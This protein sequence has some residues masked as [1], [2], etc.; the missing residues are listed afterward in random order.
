MQHGT[1]VVPKTTE[2]CYS[3]DLYAPNAHCTKHVDLQQV[4]NCINVRSGLKC[5]RKL[6]LP[7]SMM[8]IRVFSKLNLYNTSVTNAEIP[9]I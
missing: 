6:Q 5:C 9:H 4:S 1:K 7:V 3:C 2:K 8:N